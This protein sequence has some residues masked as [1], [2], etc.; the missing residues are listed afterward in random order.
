VSLFLLALLSLQGK[1]NR[2]KYQTICVPSRSADAAA[3]SAAAAAAAAATANIT[4]MPIDPST[5]KVSMPWYGK[6]WS[7]TQLGITPKRDA[8]SFEELKKRFPGIEDEEAQRQLF[9]AA[10]ADEDMADASESPKKPTVS[11]SRRTPS[12]SRPAT[13]TGTPAHSTP[14]SPTLRGQAGDMEI[15]EVEL[16]TPSRISAA[17][18]TWKT[19]GSGQLSTPSRAQVLSG[20]KSKTLTKSWNQKRAMKDAMADAREKQKRISEAQAEER[21]E[22]ARAI[23]QKAQYKKEQEAKNQQVQ[24]ITDTRKIKAMS[25]KQLRSITKM[26]VSMANKGPSV[27]SKMLSRGTVPKGQ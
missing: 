12:K 22:K 10:D 9:G 26:D 1:Q 11:L 4:A 24:V 27:T 18:A 8:P 16:N 19:P 6:E 14:G 2:G 5:G 25:R 7:K 13:R 21:R 15:G 3:A 20:N 23:A 17:G